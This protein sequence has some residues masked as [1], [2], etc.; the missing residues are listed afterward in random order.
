SMLMEDEDHGSVVMRSHYHGFRKVFEGWQVTADVVAGGAPGVE[1]HYKKLLAKLRY[2]I[3]PPEAL[4][5]KLRYQ[6]IG[7]GKM[8]D[9]IAVFKSNVERY[10]QSAN[11]YDSLAEAYEKSGKFDLARP[12]YERAVQLGTQNNDPNLQTYKT[13]FDR[14]DGM[15][16]KVA[17]GKGK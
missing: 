17:D 3:K 9:A 6:L 4:L 7:A 11:V 12:N 14:V 8:D 13:N 1:S 2:A 16:K 5:N 15:L 10:P